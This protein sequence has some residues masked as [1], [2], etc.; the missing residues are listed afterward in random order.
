MA[1]GSA[2]PGATG[3]WPD[4]LAGRETLSLPSSIADRGER[5]ER[6]GGLE[7][8]GFG[9]RSG[10]SLATTPSST[11]VRV[12]SAIE[13]SPFS[14]LSSFTRHPEPCASQVESSFPS[15]PYTN[16]FSGSNVRNRTHCKLW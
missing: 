1:C 7:V 13:L 6:S 8:R 2:S 16:A 9:G 15:Y 12:F 4:W 5:T 14:P 3:G 11:F 10:R